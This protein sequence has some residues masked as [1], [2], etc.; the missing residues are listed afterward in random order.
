MYISIYVWLAMPY[1]MIKYKIK[2]KIDLWKVNWLS[3]GTT[4]VSGHKQTI[5]PS[6]DNYFNLDNIMNK[7]PR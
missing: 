5:L 1:N 3:N 6:K 2:I 7:M 4:L